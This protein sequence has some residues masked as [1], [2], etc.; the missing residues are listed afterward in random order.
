MGCYK[1]IEMSF[2]CDLLQK[3]SAIFSHLAGVILVSTRQISTFYKVSSCLTK[4]L[5]GNHSGCFL[6]VV[7]IKTKVAFLYN[8]HT[9]SNP[10]IGSPD[11]GSIR[12]LVQALAGPISVLS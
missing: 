4:L 3:I 2:K 10:L 5:Q 6:D 1:I 8:E 12:L 7:D 11:N 9:Q